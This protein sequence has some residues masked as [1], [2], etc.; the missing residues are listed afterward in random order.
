M[1]I[2]AIVS[3]LVILS[4][5]VL[6][7]TASS[8]AGVVLS[9][10]TTI[11]KGT[12]SKEQIVP[13]IFA[14]YKDFYIEGLSLG[15]KLFEGDY[16]KTSVELSSDFLGYKHSDSIYLSTLEDKKSTLNAILKNE[17]QIFQ[18]LKLIGKLSY[19]ISNKHN[20]YSF[21]FGTEYLI[22]QK[23][24]HAIVTSFLVE[25]INNKKS[26]YYYGVNLNEINPYI[27]AYSA[28]YAYNTVLG[29][30][31][32]Y[33][34]DTKWIFFSDIKTTLLDNSISNSPIVDSKYQH[35]FLLGVL[36]VW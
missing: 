28:S 34:Y 26:N 24:N 23:N 27:N 33:L 32:S 29:V 5:T 35:N 2:L 22:F 36:Y 7:N 21:E 15:Y 31:Y 19:D 6:A 4:A 1:K 17:L 16:I 18:D 20:D 8:K 10:N 11:Y 12:S 3:F 9:H 30:K 25:Y 14:N 13:L